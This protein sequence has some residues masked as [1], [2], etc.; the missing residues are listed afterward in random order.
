[1]QINCSSVWQYHQLYNG[2]VE[3]D[4]DIVG[5]GVGISYGIQGQLVSNSLSRLLQ[6]LRS[7]H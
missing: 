7:P 5:P 1:M 4:A 6:A 2:N 3:F